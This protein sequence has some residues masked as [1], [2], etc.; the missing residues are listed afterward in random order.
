LESSVE[1]KPVAAQ[2]GKSWTLRYYAAPAEGI[3]VTLDLNSAGPV[4]VRT[5]DMSY[6]LPDALVDAHRAGPAD[7]MPSMLPYSD[8]TL[9][10]KSFTF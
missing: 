10:T 9:V 5:T 8:S 4:I 3:A 1:G 6:S 7:T 2:P